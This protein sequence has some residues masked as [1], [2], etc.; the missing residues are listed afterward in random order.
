MEKAESLSEI[1]AR[2]RKHRLVLLLISRPNCSVCQAV[3]PQIE[4][5][6]LKKSE[7]H[8]FH[9][10]ADQVTEIAGAYSV[11]AVPAVIVLAEGKEMLRKVRFIPM[12]EL[13]KQL[14]QLISAY[15]E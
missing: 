10:D 5:L 13:E 12:G 14:T 9:I 3:R 2:I 1:E 6:L 7:I 4:E 8:G 15:I 11:F